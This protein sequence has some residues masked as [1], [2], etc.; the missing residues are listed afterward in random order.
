MG[1]Q[2]S[3]KR[4]EKSDATNQTR[5]AEEQRARALE[6]LVVHD[7]VVNG[8]TNPCLKQINARAQ[9]HRVLQLR[10]PLDLQ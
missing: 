4:W 3:N 7:E 8:H 1:N 6:E 5:D 9:H 10:S 2:P